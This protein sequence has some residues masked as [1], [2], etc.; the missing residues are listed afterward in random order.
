[1]FLAEKSVAYDTVE[2]VIAEEAHLTEE[3]KRK[4]PLSQLPVLELPDG[5]LLRESMAICRFVEE[6]QPEP[7]LLG[8][9][10]WERAQIEMWNRHAELE[11]L[12][13]ISQ[14]NRN[15]HPFWAT[16]VKQAPAFGE[17]MKEH[18][19]Q[20]LAWLDQELAARPFLAGDRFT[21]ADITAV[22]ALDFAKISGIR[23]NADTH[24]NLGGW[25]RRVYERP[26]IKA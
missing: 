15:L 26:S 25:Y 9:D 21:A 6:Q 4:H 24:P 23:V 2:V 22:C 17:L 1:M 11:L 20:R 18:L 10:A 14:I 3:F 16:R 19:A 8:R 7:N 13:P 12:I 5:R